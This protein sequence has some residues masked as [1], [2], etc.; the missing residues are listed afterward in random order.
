MLS[1]VAAI[2]IF[3]VSFITS[4]AI[5]FVSYLACIE[6]P[7]DRWIRCAL[8]PGDLMVVPPGIYHRFILDYNNMIKAMMLFKVK[9]R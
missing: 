2:S 9:F 4:A 8:S 3:A 1:K 5:I 7:T 6:H